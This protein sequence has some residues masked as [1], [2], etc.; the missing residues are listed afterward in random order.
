MKECLF[1][2]IA[3]KEIPAKIIYENEKTMCI[4]DINPISDGHCILIPKKHF[5]YFSNCDDDY[6]EEMAKTT[7]KVANIINQSALGNNGINYLINEK[8]NANQEIMHLHIHLIPKFE[9]ENGFNIS[10]K[11]KNKKTI[12]E[13]Y[14]VLIHQ[15]FLK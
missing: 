12:D 10:I 3:N 7:K 13:N 14:G 1:C 15:L 5:E 8:E 11:R 6:L 2:K 9:K 4:L